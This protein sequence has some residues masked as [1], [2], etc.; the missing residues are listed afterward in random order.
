MAN[1]GRTLGSLRAHGVTHASWHPDGKIA[2]IQLGALPEAKAAA[3][4]GKLVAFAQT[5]EPEP[6]TDLDI[7]DSLPAMGDE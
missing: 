3:K 6:K 5:K 2:S 1:F 7:L 4:G